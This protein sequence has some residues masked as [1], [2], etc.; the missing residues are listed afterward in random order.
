MRRDR[1]FGAG[2]PTPRRPA[3][4]TRE[5]LVTGRRH[6]ESLGSIDTG[7]G[8]VE[9]QALAPVLALIDDAVIAVDAANAVRYMNEAAEQLTG[10]SQ[11][12]SI[13][14][15]LDSVLRLRDEQTLADLSCSRLHEATELPPRLTARLRRATATSP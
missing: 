6:D 15:P 7:A 8:S 4:D 5:G 13:G 2:T 12:E 1:D 11:G 10:H 9:M 14:A 3:R